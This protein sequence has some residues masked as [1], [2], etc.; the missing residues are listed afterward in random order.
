MVGKM[1][2]ANLAGIKSEGEESGRPRPL[3]SS[4]LRDRM[5]SGR[6]TGAG[7]SSPQSGESMSHKGVNWRQL[8]AFMP[9]AMSLERARDGVIIDAN[10]HFGELFGLEAALAVGQPFHDL[11][12]HRGERRKF[13]RALLATNGCLVNYEVQVK[14]FSGITPGDGPTWVSIAAECLDWD[15]EPVIIKTYQDIT[16]RVR[17]QAAFAQSDANLKAV[18]NSSLQSI[19][20]IDRDYKIQSFNKIAAENAELVWQKAIQEG[21]S[22]YQYVAAEDLDS[23]NVHFG[24]ALRGE[25]IRLEKPIQG[26]WFEFSYGPVFNDTG[27]VMGVCLTALNVHDR[28]QA[29]AAKAKSEAR[30]RS[31]VQYSS[32][33]IAVVSAEGTITYQSPSVERILGYEAGALLRK[34]A[35]DFIHPQERKLVLEKFFKALKQPGEVVKIEFRFRHCSGNWVYLDAVGSNWSHEPS[36]NG[37]VLNCRDVTERKQ[38][39]EKLRLLERA[40]S[41]S[42]DGIVISE[43][44]AHTPLVYV[45]P[46]F[47]QITGYTAAEVLGR[48]CSF[49]QGVDKNQPELEKLRDAIDQG[50]DCTVVLRNYRKNGSLFWNELRLSPVEND[51]GKITHYIGVQ[52]DITQR[53]A[54]EE[55][56]IHQAYHDSLTGLPNRALLMER[57]REAGIQSKRQPDYLFSVLFIDLDRFKLVNDSLG[58]AVGDMLLIV[59]ALRLEACLRPGDTLARLGGDHFVILSENIKTPDDATALA[60]SIHR[61]LQPPFCLQGHELFITASIGIALS[62]SDCSRPADLLRDADIA[63]YRAKQ[64]G[65]GRHALFDTAM[66]DR[67]VALLHLENDLR[68][69]VYELENGISNPFFLVYQPIISLSSGTLVGFEALVRWQHPERGLIS[70]TEFIPVAEESGLIV[71]LGKWILQEAC[72][73]LHQWQS[74]N[75]S[76]NA[77]TCSVNLSGKQFLQPDLLEMIDSILTATGLNSQSLKLEITESI[78]MENTETAI[79][80]LSQLRRRHI[81]L[82]L[83]DFGT[84]YSSLS[85]LHQF[86][87]DTLKIDRSF[88]KSLGSDPTH[89]KIVRAIVTLAHALEMDVTA[90]G[91]ETTNQVEQLAN[92]GCEFAQGY[93]FSPP[94]SAIVATSLVSSTEPSC[95]Y[96]PY[97]RS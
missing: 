74:E 18:L 2:S 75:P 14:K 26:V 35:L 95:P 6:K 59:I 73:Q 43:A 24:A 56:L 1:Q 71:P 78:L 85:Y 55:Q 58:H 86:P 79:A 83:D 36:I 88:V 60:E 65:K 10:A 87:C 3:L 46:S 8:M 48:N 44:K 28:Q 89:Q 16:E 20:L 61:Q 84:G 92:L 68:R 62:A 57:L 37:F 45:N 72:R 15:G 4:P 82:G 77:L 19:L 9:V 27:E 53:K 41:A 30:F 38:Q 34:N 31:L 90:E 22:I 50:T 93:F 23:F 81:R 91:I 12:C 70:P 40:I 5:H 63:M 69:A 21:D 13:L 39:E 94:V 42:S 49:L 11:F 80:T 51:Q 32:D 47:E 76:F 64:A 66:R 52:T 17:L 25:Y 29:V 97:S 67:V 7:G 54:A 96:H 33:A